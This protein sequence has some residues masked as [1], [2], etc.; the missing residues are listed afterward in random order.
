MTAPRT[1]RLSPLGQPMC[2]LCGQRF[3]S[4]A[5]RDEHE[6]LERDAFQQEQLEA[7]ELI[8]YDLR[9][10]QLELLDL[11]AKAACRAPRAGPA[12]RD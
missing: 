3:P 1:A 5:E 6:R 2:F 12:A 9:E 4:A 11:E 7:A 10:Q 8:S